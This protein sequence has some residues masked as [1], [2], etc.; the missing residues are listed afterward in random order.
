MTTDDATS[1]RP[2]TEALNRPLLWA[3]FGYAICMV[4]HGS[5]HAF[6]GLTGDDHHAVWPG[7]VQIVMAVLTVAISALAV[8]S[9]LWRYRYASVAAM[10]IGFGSASVFLLIHV[11]PEWGGFNDSFVSAQ[12][13]AQVTAYSWVTASIGIAGAVAFG[14]AG[15]FSRRK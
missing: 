2:A 13:G 10:V 7:S 3:A 9:V 15:A 8:A 6:R 14:L 4:I 11:S 1:L 5:D 12:S